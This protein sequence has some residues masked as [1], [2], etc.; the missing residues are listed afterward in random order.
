VERARAVFFGSGDFAVPVL[1]AVATAPE[2]ELVAVV[3]A[4]A[5]PVGRT[6]ELTPT[7]VA[8]VAAS[9]GVPLLTPGRLRDAGFIAAFG[10][11]DAAVG[12][13][14]DYGKLVPAA[15]LELPRHGILNLH[16][17]LLPRHRGATPVAATILA[18]DEVTGVSL[19]RMDPGLDTGPVVAVERTPVDPVEDAPQLEGRLARVA[20]TL[21]ASRIGPYLSGM[22]VPV[23]Q[24]DEGATLTRPLTRE[25]GRLAPALPAWQLERRVRAFRP[26]PGSFVELADGERLAILRATVAAGE[27]ADHPGVLVADGS[28]LA[29]A[30]GDGRL[31]LLEV[32]PAGGK[33]MDGA[34]Y[35]R[36]RP[37]AVGGRVG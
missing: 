13:L 18:G 19:I 6:R 37:A 27:P 30:T 12:V 34:A 17:S 29:L 8:A 24:P 26:W 10:A 31:R 28:G 2:L 7:A 14:A 9:V 21:L 5:R 1:E 11:L 23:A 35:R 3:T 22:L 32:R 4:P 15:L 20:A 25:D 36:G 33:A 16:P